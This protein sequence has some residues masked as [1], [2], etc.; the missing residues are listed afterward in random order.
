[1]SK[2]SD[3]RLTLALAASLI[4]GGAALSVPAQAQINV[5]QAGG[6]AGGTIAVPA[7]MP[8]AVTVEQALKAPK[9]MEAVIEGH[10]VN[11]LKHEHYTFKDASGTIEVE[12]DDKYLPTGRQITD[13][14]LIRIIGEVDTHRMKP[15]DID[16][17]RIEFVE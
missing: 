16:V 14:T 13:K 11:Q 1:M 15:N 12:I 2:K 5:P 9:D 7:V 17:K 3:R 6:T 10:I 8:R 4:A